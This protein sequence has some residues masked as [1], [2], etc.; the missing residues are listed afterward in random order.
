MS[1]NLREDFDRYFEFNCSPSKRTIYM[2]S[3]TPEME[4]G[5]GESGTDCQMAEYFVKAITHLDNTSKK[6][7][8]IIIHMNNLGGD[9][10]HGMAM[11]DAIRMCRSHVY[12]VGW[13]YVCSMGSI[14]FQAADSRIIAPHSVMMIHDGTETLASTCKGVEAWAKQAKKTRYFMYDIYLQRIKQRKSRTT[15]T[16]IEKLCSHDTIYNAHEAVD[17][18]LADWV[19]ES[20]NDPYE[21]YATETPESKYTPK[22]KTGKHEKPEESE[23]YDE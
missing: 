5:E 7:K 3:I 21:Y 14:I 23:E 10:Y 2:G 17:M 16:Q 15:L 18:G 13:G 6:P 11:F 12:M 8:P 1:Y 19:M 22:T 4:S 20:L 9:W